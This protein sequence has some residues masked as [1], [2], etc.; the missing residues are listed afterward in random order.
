MLKLVKRYL[1]PAAVRSLAPANPT[2][3][4]APVMTMSRCGTDASPNRRL[5]R[6]MVLFT[7]TVS[8][9]M[10]EVIGVESTAAAVTAQDPSKSRLRVTAAAVGRRLDDSS[11]PT[12]ARVTHCLLERESWKLVGEKRPEVILGKRRINASIDRM[13]S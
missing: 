10:A 5:S 6:G 9:A 2:P 7:S 11:G 12:T 13:V 8:F 3:L 4:L 1:W